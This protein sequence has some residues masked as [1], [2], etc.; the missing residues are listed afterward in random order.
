[1]YIFNALDI[2]IIV[3]S[4]AIISILG[5]RWYHDKHSTKDI[6]EGLV[7]TILNILRKNGHKVPSTM[8]GEWITCCS[9]DT[10]SIV[11][12]S[13]RKGGYLLNQEQLRDINLMVGYIVEEDN[14]FSV[15]KLIED[16]N[17]EEYLDKYR[18]T[19]M[20]GLVNS[21]I[22]NSVFINKSPSFRKSYDSSKEKKD[23]DLSEYYDSLYDKL[24]R[25][26]PH[27]TLIRLIDTDVERYKRMVTGLDDNETKATNLLAR[28][29]IYTVLNSC[30]NCDEN[31]TTMHYFVKYFAYDDVANIIQTQ[32][33]GDSE[34]SK[35]V[36]NSVLGEKGDVRKFLEE[37]GLDVD[38]FFRV[39]DAAGDVNVLKEK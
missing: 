12:V 9:G 39:A 24:L 16:A 38:A 1:M 30:G 33:E 34:F 21:T 5:Y 2:G 32:S 17:S 10:T 20:V 8:G 31:M 29:S 7:D 18:K 3:L 6:K 13:L 4:S 26:S 15:G 35:T 36:M 28:G 22:Y 23:E 27:A 37:K 19:M 14:E 11:T 25:Y